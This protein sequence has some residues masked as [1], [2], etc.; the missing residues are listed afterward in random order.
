MITY[1]IPFIPPSNNKYQGNG[2][3]GSNY[4]YQNEKKN[5]ADYCKLFCRPLP[6]LP[7]ELCEIT[8]EYHFKDSR[9][10]DPDNYSGKFI[11]DGMVKAGVIADDSMSVIHKLTVMQGEVDKREPHVIIFIRSVNNEQ[12]T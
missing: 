5:W 9:R 7:I 2:R 3:E 6:G 8:L 1:T 4:K 10:R 12:E 11:L